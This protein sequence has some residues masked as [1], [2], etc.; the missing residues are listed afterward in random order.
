MWRGPSGIQVADMSF[1]S[2]GNLYA[3]VAFNSTTGDAD[4][5]YTFDLT[6]GAA[7]KVGESGLDVESVGLAFDSVDNLFMKS[8]STVNSINPATGMSR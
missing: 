3:W 5:L 1:A 6:T 7:T 4:D 2:Q 8:L